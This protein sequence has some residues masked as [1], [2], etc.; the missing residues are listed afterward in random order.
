MHSKH[1][2]LLYCLCLAQVVF[3]IPVTQLWS[4]DEGSPAWRA[5]NTLQDTWYDPATGL[6]DD[7]WWNSANCLTTLAAFQATNPAE[8]SFKERMRAIYESSFLGGLAASHPDLGKKS[9][10]WINNLYDDEGWWALA[11]IKVFDVT[12]NQTY[13]SAAQDIY[14]DMKAGINNTSC[15]GLVWQRDT[16]LISSIENSLFLDVAAKLS[17]R[18]PRD[19]ESYLSDALTQHAWIFNQTALLAPTNL[20]PDGLNPTTCRPEYSGRLLTYNQGATIGALVSLYQATAKTSNGDESHLDLALTIARASIDHFSKPYAG[21][22]TEDCDPNCDT[23][24]AQFKGVFIRNLATLQQ[25]RP[26][27]DVRYFIHRNADSI[28]DNDRGG[29]A[30]DRLGSAWAGPYKDGEV[31][32][33]CSG[34]DGLVAAAM[35]GKAWK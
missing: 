6:W 34:L 29:G 12:G 18:V 25:V 4:R 8:L 28:W 30:G 15:G 21:I 9:G 33:M 14:T 35:T 5:I 16:N 22:L 20:M 23:T 3:S 24:A 32:A 17:L 13:L 31:S 19:A 27:D 7:M 2:F 26:R 11:W 1:Q 10:S